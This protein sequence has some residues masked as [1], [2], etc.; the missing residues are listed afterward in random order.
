MS[1]AVDAPPFHKL[2]LGESES[3]TRPT[4]CWF[5]PG[6]VRLFQQVKFQ[7]SG[8]VTMTHAV[9]IRA[10]RRI[11][12]DGCGAANFYRTRK[13]IAALIKTLYHVLNA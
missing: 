13:P 5:K 7:I 12:P 10:R 3:I 2:S 9:A 4:H 11:A 8:C 6:A 1:H